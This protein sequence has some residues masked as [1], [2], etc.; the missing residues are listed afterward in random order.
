MLNLIFDPK[1]YD[2]DFLL[3]LLLLNEC[4]DYH[5]ELLEVHARVNFDLHVFYVHAPSSLF[6][7]HS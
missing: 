7:V 3:N 4:F 5:D 2:T 6:R 1:K